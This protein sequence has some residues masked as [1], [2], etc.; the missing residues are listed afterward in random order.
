MLAAGKGQTRYGTARGWK[1]SKSTVANFWHALIAVLAG[2]ALYFLLM[3]HLP[4]R[5][6][7]VA[8]NM[9]LGMLVDF[10]FCLVMLGIVKT[11]VAWR[12]RTHRS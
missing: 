4:P 7:H 2:N 11:F 5:A 8:P 9:D 3:P 6:Q 1:V 12:Y 10:W